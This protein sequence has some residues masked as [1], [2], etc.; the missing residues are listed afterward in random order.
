MKDRVYLIITRHGFDRAVKSGNVQL[1]SGERMLPVD[2]EV[3]DAVFSPP[4]LPTIRLAIP[5]TAALAQVVVL[6]EHT[7]DGGGVEQAE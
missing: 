1:K 7:A 4:T 2:L 3:P 5:D 6:E